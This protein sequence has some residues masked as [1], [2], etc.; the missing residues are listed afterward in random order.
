MGFE[1]INKKIIQD[2]L[3]SCPHNLGGPIDKSSLMKCR[4]LAVNRLI[5][6]MGPEGSKVRG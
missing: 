6:L 5:L 4:H 1:K 3:L 2:S